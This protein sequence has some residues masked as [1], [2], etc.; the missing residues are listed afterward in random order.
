MSANGAITTTLDFSFF[1]GGYLQVTGDV[2][3]TIENSFV[4]T[5]LVPISGT[6]STVN[7]SFDLE[8]RIE[9]PTVYGEANLGFDF[10]GSST[11]EFGVQRYLA[12]GTEKIVL[13]EYTAESTGYVLTHAYV[14]PT[15]EF[16]LETDIFVFS[17]SEEFAGN[18]GFSVNSLGLNVSTRSYSRD[19]AS[20]CEID[21]VD[22]NDAYI[23]LESNLVEINSNGITYAEVIQK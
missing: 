23:K 5:A 6:I 12:V 1:G 17:E 11:I 14:E 20:Y 7:L 21:A 9:T 2:S 22:H 10:T 19:G 15:L 4:S 8:A 16:S 18:I 13:F 3:G